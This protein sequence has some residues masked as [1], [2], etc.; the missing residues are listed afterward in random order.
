MLSSLFAG[1]LAQYGMSEGQVE[2]PDVETPEVE[3]PEVETPEVETPEVETAEVET[4][5]DEDE[6]EDEVGDEAIEWREKDLYA[7]C[8]LLRVHNAP[9]E[10]YDEVTEDN[11]A[12]WLDEHR[13]KVDAMRLEVVLLAQDTFMPVELGRL[14]AYECYN[15]KTHLSEYAGCCYYVADDTELYKGLDSYV[16]KRR[17]VETMVTE[18]E[19]GYSKYFIG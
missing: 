8:V 11:V 16:L 1:I 10:V 4:A 17:V 6:D 9:R 14:L 5:E 12:T 7:Q 19:H 13:D 18:Y 15:T 2:T 3:T